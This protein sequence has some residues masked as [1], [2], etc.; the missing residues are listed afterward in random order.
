MRFSGVNSFVLACK[1]L[2]KAGFE[3]VFKFLEV[4][5]E[6]KKNHLI[7]ATLD[8]SLSY[9]ELC[10]TLSIVFSDSFGNYKL[11]FTFE[12]IKNEI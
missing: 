8:A 1:E 10:D 6:F 11:S 9:N 5:N 3:P 12:G 2:Q 7:I 4:R